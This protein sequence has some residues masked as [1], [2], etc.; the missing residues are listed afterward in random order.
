MLKYELLIIIL[1]QILVI[2]VGMKWDRNGEIKVWN[3]NWFIAIASNGLHAYM[4]AGLLGDD[5][6]SSD[7]DLYIRLLIGF[8][9]LIISEIC[10]I[11][12]QVNLWNVRMFPI[13]FSVLEIYLIGNLL[14]AENLLMIV[15]A[16]EVNF[17]AV[18]INFM[19]KKNSVGW[20]KSKLN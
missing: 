19:I 11:A 18:L 12:I 16:F 3:I 7:R 4:L 8:V 14:M 5:L 6:D 10:N 17:F 2:A 9:L 1:V 15:I 20:N 13:V